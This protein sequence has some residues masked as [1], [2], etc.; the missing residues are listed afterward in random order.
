M[1][2]IQCNASCDLN[3][4][5]NLYLCSVFHK[6]V[7]FHYCWELWVLIMSHTSCLVGFS[8]SIAFSLMLKLIL[9][10]VPRKSSLLNIC[11]VPNKMLRC[12]MSFTEQHYDTLTWNTFSQLSQTTVGNVP[13]NYKPVTLCKALFAQ[14]GKWMRI[15]LSFHRAL[16]LVLLFKEFCSALKL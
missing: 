10:N 16:Q 13:P 3:C 1:L 2:E 11:V 7:F 12:E 14:G 6:I 15:A 8:L 5:F 9:G 4:K